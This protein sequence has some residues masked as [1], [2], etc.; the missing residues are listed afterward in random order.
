MHKSNLRSAVSLVLLLAACGG[1]AQA[2]L[3]VNA[4]MPI[5]RVVTVQM[6]QTDDGTD[7]ATLFGTGSDQT[8][9]LSLID[10]IWAQAGINIEFL[11]PT[12]YSNAFA[13]EGTAGMMSPR[14]GGDFSTIRT[15]GALAGVNNPNPNVLDMYFVNIVPGSSLLSENSANGLASLPGKTSIVSLGMNLLD[16]LGGREV[17]AGVVAHEIGHN[18][19]LPHISILENLMCGSGA[20]CPLDAM[21]RPIDGERLT[22]AQIATA[23]GSNF[24]VAQV[25][26]IPAAVWML[27]SALVAM[28]G[29]G[30]RSNTRRLA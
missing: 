10:Q 17:I 15:Q 28:F 7:F 21:N 29:L 20:Q 16:F 5:N 24:A 6:I 30:R 1:N 2:E 23:R 19:G 26:P 3:V 27:G 8:S 9:I 12:S 18:L 14:P 22:A 4:A 11:D 13:Y 25:V